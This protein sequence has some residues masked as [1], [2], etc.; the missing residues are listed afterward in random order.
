M[1]KKQGIS[2]NASG[3]ARAWMVAAAVLIA[4][5]TA[6][7]RLSA[8]WRVIFTNDELHH[9]ES[10]RH[11]YR[12][13]DI[14]PMVVTK[15]ERSGLLNDRQF[16]LFES[17]YNLGPLAQRAL[18]V[19]FEIQP[20]SFP[21]LAEVIE[22]ITHSN[23]IALR[24]LSVVASL[25]AVL[26]MWLIGRR[27]QDDLLGFFMAGLLAIGPLTQVYAGLGRPYA[28]AQAGLLGAIYVF[29]RERSVKRSSPRR[30]LLAALLA[31]TTQWIV[32]AEVGPL[33]LVEL[34]QRWREGSSLPK[35]LRQSWW[36]GV[37]S[38]LLLCEMAFHMA[39]NVQTLKYF[40]R[41]GVL[42]H[43][44]MGSPFAHLASFGDVGLF[45]G[46]LALL[47]LMLLGAV[48]FGRDDRASLELRVGLIGALLGS[49]VAP[50]MI[51][52][53]Y[54]F[55]VTFC[56]VPTM[57]AA[58]GLRSLF[59]RPQ[60]GFAT[61]VAIVSAF[62]LLGWVHPEQPHTRI[63]DHDSPEYD[64]IAIRLA[65]ELGPNDRWTAFPYFKA[66]CLYPF[67]D[68]PEP[69]WAISFDEFRELVR[70]RKTSGSYF[71]VIRQ[72]HHP[73]PELVELLQD[74]DAEL[75]EE[76]LGNYSLVKLPPR[77]D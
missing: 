70:N 50:L 73:K 7:T 74:A 44:A 42:S 12:T 41:S 27:L 45:A 22:A 25:A 67:A 10:W 55:S 66:N 77:A 49:V 68:L 23:L 60:L 34:W 11:R 13:D 57:F 6:E 72:I 20:P 17:F 40:G 28:L 52:T 5:V 16:E 58:I 43:I 65:S 26:L 35:L 51:A 21:V 30:F 33:V 62:G 4:V 46:G 37:L 69:D 19:V 47:G 39:T 54:S 75:I 3:T 29:I 14:Y 32:W 56:V 64:E 36:Y 63:L 31:Q 18:A 53:N 38:V 15:V 2:L 9:I 48:A 71:I 61:V 1:W 59:A 8:P 24:S 76:Y